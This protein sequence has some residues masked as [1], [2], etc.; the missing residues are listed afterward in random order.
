MIRNAQPRQRAPERHQG[1][2]EAADLIERQ[3]GEK[4]TA[5]QV[6]EIAAVTRGAS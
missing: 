1:P 6:A 3:Q 5:P 4:T 2:T